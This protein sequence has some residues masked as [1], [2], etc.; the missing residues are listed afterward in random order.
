MVSRQ[1]AGGFTT[2]TQRTQ[3]KAEEIK[4]GVTNPR[5]CASLTEG[6][7]PVSGLFSSVISVSLWW[8]SFELRGARPDTCS[9]S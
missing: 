2:E 7:V 6:L 3:R 9:E 8:I 4:T 5:H 1:T